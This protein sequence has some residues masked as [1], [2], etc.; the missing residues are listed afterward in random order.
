MVLCK[1]RSMWGSSQR[2]TIDGLIIV[3]ITATF[4]MEIF[5][6]EAQTGAIKGVSITSFLIQIVNLFSKLLFT[7]QSLPLRV[8]EKNMW[9]IAP[10]YWKETSSTL[11]F[12]N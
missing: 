11:T 2:W 3:L 4:F 7:V 8:K 5:S 9:Q 1:E 10:S 12:S 6:F